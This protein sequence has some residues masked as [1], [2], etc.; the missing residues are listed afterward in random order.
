MHTILR[1]CEI[2]FFFPVGVEWEGK[3]KKKIVVRF[4]GGQGERAR[5]KKK[6][7]PAGKV[8]EGGVEV[9]RFS[10]AGIWGVGVCMGYR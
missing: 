1:I 4:Q 7:H 2:F 5:L 10:V 3:R 8:G 9:G 6:F